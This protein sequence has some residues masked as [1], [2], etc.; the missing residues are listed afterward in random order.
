MS[1]R[2]RWWWNRLRCP[3]PAALVAVVA[4]DVVTSRLQAATIAAV[5]CLRMASS[6]QLWWN[7][8]EN[9]WGGPHKHMLIQKVHIS[10]FLKI[11]FLLIYLD[12]L[13]EFGLILFKIYD[14]MRQK[15]K[16]EMVFLPEH[17]PVTLTPKGRAWWRITN[18][19]NLVILSTF[20]TSTKQKPQLL[21]SM[22]KQIYK[23][24]LISKINT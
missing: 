21:H 1:S 16:F 10:I 8:R 6:V 20:I 14:I 4:A 7:R 11:V 15:N 2:S 17:M 18:K 24:Y 5:S 13:Q 3:P 12:S 22:C 23:N 19:K 9:Y